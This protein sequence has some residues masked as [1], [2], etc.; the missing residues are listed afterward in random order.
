MH[1]IT[2]YNALYNLMPTNRYITGLKNAM[3]YN[4]GYFASNIRYI[5]LLT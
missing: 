2:H 4:Y 1:Y 5:T 3:F